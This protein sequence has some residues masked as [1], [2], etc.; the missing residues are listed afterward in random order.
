MIVKEDVDMVVMGSRGRMDLEQ[1]LVGSVASKIF[2]KSPATVV[3]CQ[4][5][6]DAAH[7]RRNI[8]LTG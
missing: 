2:R 4:S 8:H 6:A 5:E 7:L 1:V 3:S